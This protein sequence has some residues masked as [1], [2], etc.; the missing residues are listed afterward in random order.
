M[1]DTAYR[2]LGLCRAIKSDDFDR[3]LFIIMVTGREGVERIDPILQGE[4]NRSTCDRFARFP[5][6]ALLRLALPLSPLM[7]TSSAAIGSSTFTERVNANWCLS[8]LRID[9]SF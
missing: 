1:T 7:I 4:K 2:G 5:A 3:Y 9:C 6:T 8:N